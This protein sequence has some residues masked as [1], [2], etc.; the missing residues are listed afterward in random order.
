MPTPLAD[1]VAEKAAGLKPALVE[2]LGLPW[3]RRERPEKL[4]D[5]DDEGL[6]QAAMAALILGQPLILAGDPG[7]GKTQFAIALATRLGLA[8]QPPHH[9]KSTSSGRDLFYTFDEV[10]RFRGAKSS[11]LRDFVRFNAVGRAILWSAGPRAPVTIGA[12]PWIEIAGTD[13]AEEAEKRPITLG[14]LFPSAFEYFDNGERSVLSEAKRS[15]ALVDEFDKA[16]RDAPN[17]ILAEIEDMAFKIEE[18]DIRV[19]ADD[20]RWPV[21]ILTSNSERSLPDAFLRRCVFHWINFPG[22]VRLRKIVALHCAAAEDAQITGD[23]GLV[24]G[25]VDLFERIRGA[26]VNK[27]PATAELIAFV[28]ALYEMG[29]PA[30]QAPEIGD[31]RVAKSLG[32][33]LKTRVDRVEVDRKIAQGTL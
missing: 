31:E 30:D 23:S 24:K 6:V 32:I 5:I 12:L 1:V 15:V 14:D 26:C 21:L 28:L 18:L 22:A 9:V 2:A 11:A 16:P 8:F 19:H 4:Y 20:A 29:L 7:V 27:K 17:D 25:A 10:A 3:R 33:L 13:I